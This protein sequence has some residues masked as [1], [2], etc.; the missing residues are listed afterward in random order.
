MECKIKTKLEVS[1]KNIITNKIKKFNIIYIYNLQ[2][3]NYLKYKEY[4]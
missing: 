4:N 3:M 2:V 1:I